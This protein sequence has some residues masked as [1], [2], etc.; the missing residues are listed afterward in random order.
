MPAPTPQ[1]AT[2]HVARV[3][4]EMERLKQRFQ[5]RPKDEKKRLSALERL[6]PKLKRLTKSLAD[7][8]VALSDDEQKLLESLKSPAPAPKSN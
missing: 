8:A 4:N 1:E 6:L 5:Q 3:W 2:Q 7:S